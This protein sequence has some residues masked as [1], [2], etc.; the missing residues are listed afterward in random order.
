[1]QWNAFWLFLGGRIRKYT[2][3]GLNITGD[4]RTRNAVRWHANDRSLANM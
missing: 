4:A 3:H 1:M 2:H